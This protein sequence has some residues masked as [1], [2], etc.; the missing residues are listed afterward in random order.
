MV[1]YSETIE[2]YDIKVSKNNEYDTRTCVQEL[3]VI[4]I[5]VHGHS[6]S[7]NFQQFLPQNHWTDW[8]SDERYRTIGPLVTISETRAKLRPFAGHRPPS[9]Q[10]EFVP[11]DFLNCI[12]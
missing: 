7:I 11:Y 9:P 10:G 2:V 6:D 4:F 3:K 8:I 1:D 5:F 12:I